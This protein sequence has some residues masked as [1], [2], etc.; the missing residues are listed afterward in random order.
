MIVDEEVVNY[1]KYI[2]TIWFEV[3]SSLPHSQGIQGAASFY[4]PREN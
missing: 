2:I 3:S 4:P 1:T